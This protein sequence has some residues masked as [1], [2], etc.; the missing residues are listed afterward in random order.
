[1]IAHLSRGGEL[2]EA[3]KRLLAFLRD[4][5]ASAPPELTAL[6]DKAA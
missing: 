4:E 1:V 3:E 6:Y 2:T 5:A